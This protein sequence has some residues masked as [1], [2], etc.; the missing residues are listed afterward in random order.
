[1]KTFLLSSFLLAVSVRSFAPAQSRTRYDVALNVKRK[2]RLGKSS[3]VLVANRPEPR[4]N[5]QLRS[6]PSVIL[7]VDFNNVRGKVAGVLTYRQ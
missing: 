1:M 6:D 4:L 5:H 7:I 3:H 2:L